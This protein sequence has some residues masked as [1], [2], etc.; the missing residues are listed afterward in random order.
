MGEIQNF[1]YFQV[2]YFPI[3]QLTERFQK[4][5]DALQYTHPKVAKVLN[6]LVESYEYEV[7]CRHPKNDDGFNLQQGAPDSV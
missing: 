2:G 4:Q 7:E 6:K 5:A 3:R 1:L